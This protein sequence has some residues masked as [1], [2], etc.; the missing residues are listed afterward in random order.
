MGNSNPLFL[1]IDLGTTNG[2]VACFD[3]WGNLQASSSR[4]TTTFFPNPGWY[5]Q[6][7]EQWLILLEEALSEIVSIL[8][9][10]SQDIEAISIANF[11]PGMIM[12]QGNSVLAP[13]PTWQD[14]RCWAQGERLI[15]EVGPG[16]IGLGVPQTGFPAKILWANENAPE[17][18]LKADKILDIKAYLLNWLTGV[19]ATDPSSGPGAKNWHTPVFDYVDCP[20]ERLPVVK[21]TTDLVGV[22]KPEIAERVGLPKGISVFA[23][24][25]DGAAA[26]LGS[27]VCK[28]GQTII[29]LAT[30]GVVRIVIPGPLD[31]DL[32]IKKGLFNWPF[33]D[34][35]WI[36]GGA[37][38]SGAGSLQWIADLLGI[39]NEV[40]AYNELLDNASQIPIGSRG[41]VF[42]PYLAGRGTPASDPKVR[43]GF[44]NLGLEHGRYELVRAVLEGLTFAILEIFNEIQALNFVVKTINLT[45]GGARS[46]LWQQMISDVLE[47]QLLYAGGDA[48]LGCAIVAAVGS[49]VYTSFQEAVDNMVHPFSQVVPDSQRSRSYKQ[50]FHYFQHTR[51]AVL[52]APYPRFEW[53]CL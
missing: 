47:S 20:I 21:Q 51:D 22:I 33:I 24:L 12:I 23:G 38:L 53:E 32:L 45:G 5:E 49:G 9:L 6:R 13:C 17:L 19:M 11:G 3:R 2:K 4:P 37:T 50:V 48:T 27:G 16:W 43:G 25:N 26:T 1:G 28:Y 44:L 18:I 40:E 31:G 41:V 34:D 42:I 39:P 15:E 8:G 14:E 10:K 36:C 7:P 46:M 30:N 29:T 35:M 52:D